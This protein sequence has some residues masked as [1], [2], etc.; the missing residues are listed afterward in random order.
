MYILFAVLLAAGTAGW[1]TPASGQMNRSDSSNVRTTLILHGSAGVDPTCASV[2]NACDGAGPTV[3]VTGV[4][5][6]SIYLLLGNYERLSGVQCAFEW[7]PSWALAF[8]LWNCQESALTAVTPQASGD[9]LGTITVA[10]NEISG[11]GTV[12]VGVLSFTSAGTGCISLVE[13]VYPFGNHIFDIHSDPQNIAI[14]EANW[15]RVCVGG[16]GINTCD[17]WLPAVED[18]TWGGIK[19]QYLR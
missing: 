19:A 4:A 14:D 16:G 13:S 1:L 10:F 17:T 6:P 9:S 8:G 11:G 2:A 3:D 5:G 15:G 12:G 7:D 18:K